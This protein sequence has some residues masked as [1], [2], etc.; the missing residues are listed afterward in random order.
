MRRRRVNYT[1]LVI[2]IRGTDYDYDY[3]YG[4]RIVGVGHFIRLFGYLAISFGCSPKYVE[5]F[6]RE[7]ALFTRRNCGG[8]FVRPAPPS[9][10]RRHRRWP[11]LESML[12]ARPRSRARARTCSAT[13]V[14]F[15][16][17][18]STRRFRCCLIAP[19][20]C[21]G[22][23]IACAAALWAAAVCDVGTV[24]APPS[25]LPLPSANLRI[26][27]VPVRL[28]LLSA[29]SRPSRATDRRPHY[30]YPPTRI[31]C[32][33]F[34]SPPSYP[35][36]RPQIKAPFLSPPAP[37]TR[38]VRNYSYPY[39]YPSPSPAPAH[40]HIRDCGNFFKS[41]LLPVRLAG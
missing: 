4:M 39:P 33:P 6:L 17:Y 1:E 20:A 22:I 24:P 25:H 14:A 34:R 8:I 40:L 13:R 26:E 19:V 9:R 16:F 32:T 10:R 21:S 27:S 23:A 29:H 2:R 7:S 3:D 38:I 41:F 12:R 35:S 36:R 30:L 28:P 31:P 11:S 15:A 37:H 5:F 18:V